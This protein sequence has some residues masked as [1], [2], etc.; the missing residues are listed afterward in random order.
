MND[1]NFFDVLAIGIT[2]T[3]MLV[4]YGGTAYL[5]NEHSWS[6][7][8]FLFTTLVVGGIKVKTGCR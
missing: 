1:T 2:L 4:A 3:F 7:W 6:P 8:W 5:V